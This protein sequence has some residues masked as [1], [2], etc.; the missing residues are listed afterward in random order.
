MSSLVAITLEVFYLGVSH[1]PCYLVTS[2][3]MWKFWVSIY[4]LEK[5]PFS[6]NLHTAK[7][8]CSVKVML[9]SHFW[10]D[11]FKWTIRL[12]LVQ[13]RKLSLVKN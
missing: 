6:G 10:L 9:Y 4:L 11:I 5:A 3:I 2:W 8:I 1:L 7:L 12:Q 13:R